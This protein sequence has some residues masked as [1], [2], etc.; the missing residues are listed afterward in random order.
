MLQQKLLRFDKN[1]GVLMKISNYVSG[2]KSFF[3]CAFLMT[4]LFVVVICPFSACKKEKPS[5]VNA[6]IS[7]DAKFGAANIDISVEEFNKL[8]FALGDSCDVLFSNG[9]KLTDV[10][11]YNGYYVKNASPVI[12]AY[13]ANEYVLITLNNNGIW[14][15]AN[16]TDDC[17]VTITL[18]TAKKYIATQQ[19]LG[20][21]Y[22]LDR[23][24]YASDEEFVNF[25][26][27]SGGNL[28]ANF[29]FRGASP[30][31]NSR[32]RASYADSL[33][34]KN[35]I[36]YVVD[37]ADSESDVAKYFAEEDFSS[38]YTKSL[39]EKGQIVLLSMGSGYTST[40]Y[41]QSVVKG[42]KSMLAANG[43]YY[44]HCME[45]KDRTGFV[46]ALIEALA[47]A[48]YDEMCADYMTTYKNYYKITKDD[49]PDKYN[50]VVKLYFDSFM[51]CIGG[52]AVENAT[53][54]ADYVTGAK[55][56]L[57]SGGMS[58]ED[59]NSFI[60]LISDPS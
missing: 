46:C 8:G 44:I 12:V 56:Y 55:N 14:L 40:A 54:N 15:D 59:I 33:L 32:N 2:K 3:A 23:F 53:N 18:N 29:I 60:G 19:A 34:R 16:L 43:P 4:L 41:R 30:L 20:Q 38:A 45:G 7:E 58:E 57:K 52:T 36:A 22:S 49:M 24:E 31:D 13:P 39:Y 17:T 25:R 5:L 42:F 51:E 47:G 37:L 1:S 9:Y 6:K 26:A 35:N 27:L 10:P 21:S 11:Y 48:N 50:A 28:K